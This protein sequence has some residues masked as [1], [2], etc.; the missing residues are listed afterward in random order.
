MQNPNIILQKRN[1][2]QT[3]RNHISS[4]AVKINNSLFE[5]ALLAIE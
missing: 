2:L 4:K 3:R 5:Y 1:K